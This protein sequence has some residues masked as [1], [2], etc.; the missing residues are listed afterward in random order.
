MKVQITV[1]RSSREYG[2]VVVE[3]PSVEI[4]EAYVDQLLAAGV[5]S[6][7][8]CDLLNA[9]F[10]NSGDSADDDEVIDSEQVEDDLTADAIIPADWTPTPE[11]PRIERHPLT[12]EPTNEVRA[13]RV[14][15]AIEA[16]RTAIYGLPEEPATV[17]QDFIT[18]VLHWLAQQPDAAND[19]TE[20]ARA[21]L[22][23]HLVEVA[24]EQGDMGA[25]DMLVTVDVVRKDE[26]Q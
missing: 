22:Y 23:H 20:V 13:E 25:Q 26:D 8:Y 11:P 12:D 24:Q 19:A 9:A 7:A 15:E 2:T 18:D 16:Y 14:T 6:Q 17:A 10:W 5:D 21:A 3:A 4:G 1:A